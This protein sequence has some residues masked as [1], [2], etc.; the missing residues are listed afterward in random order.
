MTEPT[1][2]SLM[3]FACALAEEIGSCEIPGIVPIGFGESIAALKNI[4]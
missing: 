4:G 3:A 2:R 1:P